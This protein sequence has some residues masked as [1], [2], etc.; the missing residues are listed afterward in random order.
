MANTVNI[1]SFNVSGIVSPQKRS[2]VLSK[3]KNMVLQEIKMNCKMD[4]NRT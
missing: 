4:V 1:L 2:K 3:V